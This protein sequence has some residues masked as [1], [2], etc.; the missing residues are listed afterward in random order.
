MNSVSKKLFLIQ[1]IYQAGSIVDDVNRF[2]SAEKSVAQFAET[3]SNS[4]STN[5]NERN[6]FDNLHF[7]LKCKNIVNNLDKKRINFSC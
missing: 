7:E 3:Q 6:Y 5:V 4:G 2:R 1:F